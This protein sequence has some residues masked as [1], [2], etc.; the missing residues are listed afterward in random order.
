MKKNTSIIAFRYNLEFKF[1]TISS[2]NVRVTQ[3]I[4][5]ILCIHYKIANIIS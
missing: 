3:I 2:H 4:Y 1:I 5:Y